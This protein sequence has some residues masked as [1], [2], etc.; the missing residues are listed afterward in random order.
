MIFFLRDTNNANVFELELYYKK[1]DYNGELYPEISIG[2]D[3]VN[4]Y[5]FCKNVSN[6]PEGEMLNDFEFL[7]DIR[8]YYYETT[9]LMKPNTKV[10][11]IESIR[12]IFKYY[13]NKYN[14]QYAED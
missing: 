10:E 13:S 3:F 2:F 1:S 14:L 5:K 12:D 11:L 6:I 4:A 8:G 7:D 9:D